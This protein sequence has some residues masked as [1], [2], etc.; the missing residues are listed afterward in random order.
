MYA[1]AI[2]EC[3]NSTLDGARHGFRARAGVRGG[4]GKLIPLSVSTVPYA[5]SPAACHQIQY[6]PTPDA[7]KRYP[8][9]LDLAS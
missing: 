9:E 5:S 3:G 6:A 1:H 4:R 7:D 8:P 2:F